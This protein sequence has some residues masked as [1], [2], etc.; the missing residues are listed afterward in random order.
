MSTNKAVLTPYP[1]DKAYDYSLPEHIEAGAGDYV[2]VPLGSRE[3][4]AVVW[5]EGAG[6]VKPEKIKSILSKYD[7]PP[8]PE[9]HRKFLDWMAGYTMAPKGSV[10][11]LTLSVPK[12][13]EPP[14]TITGYVIGENKPDETGVSPAAKRILDV[15]QDGLPRRASELADAAGCST[16][17][18][19]TLHNKGFL[20]TI[21][22]QTPPPCRVP[23]AE[24]AGALL[25]TPQR[26]CADTLVGMVKGEKYSAALLDGV[27]G[28]GKTEV[29]FE[30]VAQVLRQNKQVLIL[31]PEIAL[32]NAFLDRFKSRF[33]CAPAL[34]HSSLSVAKRKTT[35]RGVAEGQSRVI[36]GARSALFLPFSDLGLIIVDE[37][38]DPAYKQEEG[39]IYHARDMAV[40]R[41]NLGKFPIVMV[42]ATPSLETMQNAW[43]GRYA[44]L[45]LPDRHGGASLPDIHLIDLKKDKPEDRQH[46]IAPTL[47]KAVAEAIEKGQQA[48]LF[49]NRRGYAPLTL[50]RHCGH[51]FQ[52]P[53]CTAWLI[54][55]RRTGKLH[56]H[57]CDH[58]MKMPDQC[59]ECGE[60]DSLAACGP[61]VERVLEEVKE[62]FPEARVSV[63]SSDTATTH[64]ELKTKL[65]EIQ[66]GE[67]DIIIGTQIIAK[68]H[69]FPKLTCVGVIDADLG[70][71]GGDLRA[72]ERVYQLLHQVAGRAGREVEKGV[73]YLQTFSPET[74]VM[75]ALASGDRDDFLEVELSE[76]EVSNMPPFS[77]LVG[78]I[79]SGRDEKEVEQA[80]MVLGRAAPQGEKI[81]T[82]GPAEAPMYRLRGKFR[83]RLLVRAEKSIDI[84]KAIKHWISGV[85]LPSKIRVQID[86]DP[87][88]FY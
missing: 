46:F 73:V 35:W 65:D 63:L 18:I 58:Y 81:Q 48:L 32:S 19:K 50:C 31:L 70:L 80:A 36:I 28:A 76:R 40:V 60:V 86:I 15:A 72:T 17:V 11:K 16:G 39:V 38:H 75:Q 20:K 66:N 8:L 87:Q 62:I 37:E 52:C 64:E 9:V 27:T 2:C 83:R 51:R 10:L 78:I 47:E 21:E 85:K 14:A 74:R 61:G 42:S 49:L 25:S 4:P 77:R 22:L 53:R 6:D 43:A 12:A 41:A 13:L 68:G 26:E 23:D 84:Q 79:V 88:S 1:I 67:V 82:L 57:H 7:L 69:H 29:Y 34:W 3:I 44:H 59:P 45:S 5:G 30:A 56:C 54:E 71:T 33:G 24:R 55:H